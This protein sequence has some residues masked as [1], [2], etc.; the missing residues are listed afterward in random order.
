MNATENDTHQSPL[1]NQM[2]L[3]S[4]GDEQ[5]CI[6]R[7]SK[8]ALKPEFR[9]RVGVHRFWRAYHVAIVTNG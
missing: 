9:Q 5:V 2:I 4:S 7:T 6:S 3:H 8:G 1:R